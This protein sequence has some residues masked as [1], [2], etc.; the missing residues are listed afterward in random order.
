VA[1]ATKFFVICN[2]FFNLGFDEY[3]LK[4][5]SDEVTFQDSAKKSKSNKKKTPL[6][7]EQLVT[8]VLDK[9]GE[10]AKVSRPKEAV[11]RYLT[12]LKVKVETKPYFD[13]FL[14]ELQE[15]L[16]QIE[17]NKYL[18]ESTLSTVRSILD[19]L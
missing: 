16:E 11:D 5:N 18:N 8:K 6:R 1:T 9:L 13:N 4:H 12:M 17:K 14:P 10:I 7:L 19:S 3:I 15:R 2:N